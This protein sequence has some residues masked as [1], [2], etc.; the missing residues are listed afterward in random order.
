MNELI[1]KRTTADIGVS[2]D[3]VLQCLGDSRGELSEFIRDGGEDAPRVSRLR[4]RTRAEVA[5]APRAPQLF[6]RSQKE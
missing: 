6:R 4:I 1:F 3:S 2:I 5:G